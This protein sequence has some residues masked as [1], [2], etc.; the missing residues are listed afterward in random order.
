MKKNSIKNT[1]VSLALALCLGLLPGTVMAEEAE[2][3]LTEIAQAVETTETSAALPSLFTARTTAPGADNTYFFAS[4]PYSQ[5]GYGLPNCTAYAF[6]RAYEILGTTPNLAMGN[7]NSWWA[8]NQNTGYYPSGSTPKLGAVICWGGSSDGHVAIVEAINGDTVTLSE[9]TY[10]GIYFQN[11]TYTIGAEDATS[12]G[13]FQGYIYIGDYIDAASDVTPPSL[14]DV[15]VTDYQ[16]EGIKV[17]AL[18]S[19]DLSGIGSVYFPVWTENNG[20]DDLIWHEGTVDGNVASCFIPYSDHN[21]ELGDYNVHIYAY[22][23]AGHYT[24]TGTTI[25]KADTFTSLGKVALES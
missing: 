23:N 16:D 19:D 8:Y 11:Y 4:N 20:Q 1:C 22:D 17:T 14:S 2:L 21:T 9:S 24:M 7:A 12:V 18:V 15:L 10:S 6:G 13:G 5:G 25:T 3:D